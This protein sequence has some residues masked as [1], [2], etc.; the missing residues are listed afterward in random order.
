MG[1]KCVFLRKVIVHNR[2]VWNWIYSKLLEYMREVMQLPQ[3]VQINWTT[4]VHT[5]L[6]SSLSSDV[7]QMRKKNKSNPTLMI[8]IILYKGSPYLFFSARISLVNKKTGEIH[9]QIINNIF[10][11]CIFI[12]SHLIHFPFKSFAY[13]IYSYISAGRRSYFTRFI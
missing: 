9:L 2:S 5:A 13:N 12:L 8:L 3:H 4:L 6:A 7:P 11:H 10:F 1:Y